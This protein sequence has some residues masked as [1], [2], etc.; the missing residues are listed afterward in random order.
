MTIRLGIGLGLA[1]CGGLAVGAAAQAGALSPETR[2]FV[3]VEAASLALV[4]ARVIDGTGAE[5]RID[6]TL[7][8][9][10]GIIRAMGDSA[11]VSV[12][13][14]ARVLDLAG[15]TVLPGLVMVH[16]HMFY[17]GARWP[18]G[19]FANEQGVRCSIRCTSSRGRTTLAEWWSTGPA[20]A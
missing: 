10:R 19:Y 14:G 11:H 3:K 2:S 9:E 8:V 1:A 17:P 18:G 16:E 12:P 13:P 5:P 15:R 20:W 4:H 6:Q 7:L